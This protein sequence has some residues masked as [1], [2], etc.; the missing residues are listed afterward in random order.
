MGFKTFIVLP[1]AAAAAVAAARR[2]GS[3]N[4]RVEELPEPLRGP[5]YAARRRLLSAKAHAREA[6]REGQAEKHTAE[7]E[8]M[9]EYH[10]RSGH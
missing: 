10:R 9:A 2:L 5:A 1:L 8:L 6:V 7:M 4:P 3:D